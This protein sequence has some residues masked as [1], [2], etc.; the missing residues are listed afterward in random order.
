MQNI[1]IHKYILKQ[2]KGDAMYYPVQIP[3]I[4]NTE[5][6]KHQKYIE[7]TMEECKGFVICFWEMRPISYTC[8]A[9]EN[10]IVADACIDLVVEFDK[11]EIGF[12]GMRKTNFH[13]TLNLPSRCFGVRMMPGAFQQ[14]TGFAAATAMDAF[15]PIEKVFSDFNREQ[16]FS[17]SFEEAMKEMKA[18]LMGLIKDKQP[19]QFTRLFHTLAEDTP[20]K[21]TE[22]YEQVH[23]SP[24]QCQRLFAKH[25][26][27]TPQVA[28]SIVRFQKCM[29]ILT[30]SEAKPAD[31]L[32]VT[33]FYDQPHFNND[34][35][36]NIGIT[37]LEL[38]HRYRQ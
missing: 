2:G 35:K 19:N 24:R 10:I 11:K 37:P 20:M 38:I 32:A 18:L 3:Y 6:A 8:L 26:G 7:T 22:L 34:F 28:L 29:E 5:Y 12:A 9:V 27:I 30:S 16:F 4:L 13:Y 15:L 36:R 23:F 17:L 14:L 33:S 21:V 31:I 25:Y 1:L